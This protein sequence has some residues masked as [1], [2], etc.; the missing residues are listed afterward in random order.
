MLTGPSLHFSPSGEAECVRGP[1]GRGASRLARAGVLDSTLSTASKRNEVM[2]VLSR[3][4][5]VRRCER[6]ARGRQTEK[7]PSR[8]MKEHSKSRDASGNDENNEED[9]ETGGVSICAD[10]STQTFTIGGIN[11]AWESGPK[12]KGPARP[13]AG[14]LVEAKL[15]LLRAR[16]LT[17]VL[18][19]ENADTEPGPHAPGHEP[20]A[21]EEY[22][23]RIHSVAVTGVGCPRKPPRST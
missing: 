5:P 19:R 1:A 21:A 4:S 20:S 6:Q 16:L 23:R 13:P 2:A 15:Q 17:K 9:I 7:T 8:A 3:A 12:C 10:S 22:R 14:R 18:D 11:V